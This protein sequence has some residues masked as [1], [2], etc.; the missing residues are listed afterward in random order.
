[1][2]VRWDRCSQAVLP[3]KTCRKKIWIVTIG[4]RAELCHVMP[5]ARQAS[6]IAAEDSSSVQFCLKRPTISVILRMAVPPVRKELL[7]NNSNTQEV[8]PSA[9]A[10]SDAI[11]M[12]T[13]RSSATYENVNAIRD[14]SHFFARV[15]SAAAA[16]K[17]QSADGCP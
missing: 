9:D 6:A 1:M 8:P 2:P 14:E 7:N 17:P 4:L 15:R 3:C 16:A 5:A 12:L 10:S 11:A 13:R